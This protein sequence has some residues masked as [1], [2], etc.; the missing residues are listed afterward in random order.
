MKVQ[1]QSSDL[2][3]FPPAIP[4]HVKKD[5]TKSKDDDKEKYAK[6]DVPFKNG[7]SEDNTEWSI[8]VFEEGSAEDYVKWR[9][10]F[11][12]LAGA[13]AIDSPE[14]QYAILQ[15]ILRGEARSRF[16]VGYHSIK[17]P[18]NG[19][20]SAKEK[21][22]KN[23]L[24]A[25]FNHLSKQLFAPPESAW[26]RQRTYMRYHLKFQDMSVADFKRR[27]IEVNNYL[28]YFPPPE[29]KKSV[30][31][32]TEDELVEIMDRAK[33]VEYQLDVLTSNYDP[34][35]KTLLEY[36]EYLE[37]LETKH[38]IQK[39][40]SKGGNEKEKQLGLSYRILF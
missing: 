26:R 38:S 3:V 9:V 35:S 22:L 6:F 10:R 2:L 39:A 13:M 29:G 33:P 32:L 11:D 18:D 27:L 1:L 19:T 7:E 25:G 17:L 28:I 23:K 12:E 37:R 4:F 5:K 20:A 15:T 24:S 8:K 40:I 30:S 36:T 21:A 31:K 14:N 34:Y 16:N